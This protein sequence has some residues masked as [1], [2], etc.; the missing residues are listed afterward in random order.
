MLQPSYTRI[1]A[2]IHHKITKLVGVSHRATK[3]DGVPRV[4]LHVLSDGSYPF[5]LLLAGGLGGDRALIVRTHGKHL[6][7]ARTHGQVIKR[8]QHM[9][10]WWVVSE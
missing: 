5:I 6:E 4:R 8:L 3:I 10:I 7:L 1:H 2:H 9:I